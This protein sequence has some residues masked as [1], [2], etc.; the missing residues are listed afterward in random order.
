MQGFHPNARGKLKAWVKD[1]SGGITYGLPMHSH[2]VLWVFAFWNL[3]NDDYTLYV[4]EK[5]NGGDV[6][7]AVTFTIK[8][9]ASKKSTPLGLPSPSY[10][11]NGTA[12][13]NFA[14]P[15]SFSAFGMS[16]S[17]LVGAQTMTG[18]NGT[19]AV[20]EG[21]ISVQPGQFMGLYIVQ[22]TIVDNPLQNPYTLN[23]TNATGTTP[24]VFL[25]VDL[26]P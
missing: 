25:K 19:G 9:K 4:A 3:P 18:H 11:S 7:N 2:S 8:K 15:A 20:T 5:K 1:K 24:T 13:S 26:A 23:I 14:V 10:P 12:N 21:T 16:D 6:S 17:N 22:F